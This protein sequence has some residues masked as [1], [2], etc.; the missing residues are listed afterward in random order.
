M[1]KSVS[2]IGE[3]A[4]IIIIFIIANSFIQ[5]FVKDLMLWIY[6]KRPCRTEFDTYL[7]LLLKFVNSS[8][9]DK[10]H[11]MKKRWSQALLSFWSSKTVLLCAIVLYMHRNCKSSRPLQYLN[12]SP[13]TPDASFSNK[14]YNVSL[15]N[16]REFSS[17][18]VILKT[19]N[20]MTRWVVYN[21]KQHKYKGSCL[22]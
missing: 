11:S 1:E 20:F 22:Q 7:I 21:G 17:Q 13:H 4:I 10:K 14:R 16:I 19:N 12:Q 18:P 5:T 6:I 2:T 3:Y 9:F 15:T 8:E